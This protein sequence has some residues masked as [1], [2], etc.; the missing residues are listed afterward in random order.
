MNR[1]NIR[2]IPLSSNF[3]DFRPRVMLGRAYS[4]PRDSDLLRNERL[5]RMAVTKMDGRLVWYSLDFCRISKFRSS[6]RP[7]VNALISA[8]SLS[9]C[10][11]SPTLPWTRVKRSILDFERS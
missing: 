4:T 1:C 7:G 2:H 3:Y 6:H 5:Y 9:H 10:R 8:G 11:L